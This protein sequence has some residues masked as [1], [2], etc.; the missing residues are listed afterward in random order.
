MNGIFHLAFKVKDIKSTILFYHNILGCSLGRQTDNWVDFNFFG[1]QISA[2]VSK[3][4]SELDYCGKV[5]GLKVPIPHFGCIL[6]PEDFK[7][8]KSRLEKSDIPFL[9]PPQTRYK[10]NRGEQQTMFVLD[11]SN[12]ALEFKSFSNAEAIFD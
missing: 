6:E 8:I 5:E 9:V 11:P 1:H 2:H 3:N 10:N 7:T 4:I 12:N